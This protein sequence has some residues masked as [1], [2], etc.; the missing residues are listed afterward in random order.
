MEYQRRNAQ[1]ELQDIK[2]ENARQERERSR[3]CEY[4]IHKLKL[5]DQREKARKAEQVRQ[6]QEVASSRLN[7]FR[8]SR[9]QVSRENYHQ[10]LQSTIE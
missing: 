2:E 4:L 8:T 1:E 5:M 9:V 6:G 3:H 7:D 10:K